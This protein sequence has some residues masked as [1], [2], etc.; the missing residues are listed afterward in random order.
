MR[1]IETKRL[2]IRNWKL[3]DYLDI[4]ELNSDEKVNPSAGCLVIK[5][6]EKAKNMLNSLVNSNLSFAIELKNENKVIGT[7][8]MDEIIPD[9]SF[10]NLKQRYIGY[11]LNSNY[12]DKGYATEATKYFIKYLFEELQLDLIWSSHFNFNNKSKNVLNKCGFNYKFSESKI[13]KAL[14]NRMV[15]ELF[16]NMHKEEYYK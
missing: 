9:K 1:K 11:R 2:I 14:E 16:Y 5:D 6:M 10:E 8:G 13:V 15:T 12:W 7:I 4:Y 3:N